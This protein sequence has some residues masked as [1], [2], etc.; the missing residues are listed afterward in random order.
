[1]ALTSALTSRYWQMVMLK[2]SGTHQTKPIDAAK[3]WITAHWQASPELVGSSDRTL[4]TDLWHLWKSH[5]DQ[6]PMAL[7]CLRCWVSHQIAA[8]C[9]QI[10]EQFGTSYGF[11]ASDLWPLVLDDDG[12]EI[13]AYQPLSMR[14]LERYD[15]TQAAL[16]TWANRMTKGHSEI[17]RF[18]LERGLYRI[19]DWALLND[20][21]LQGL[22]NA[23][24]HLSAAEIEAKSTLLAAYH[25]VY[26][27]DRIAQRQTKGRASRCQEPTP[28]Q[29][30]EISPKQPPAQVLRSLCEL[31][32]QMRAHRVSVRRGMPLTRPFDAAAENQSISRQCNLEREEDS[33]AQ[34][35]F[36]AR[37]RSHFLASLDGAISTVAEGF[38]ANY[39]KK[40][41]AKG[42]LFLSALTLFHCEGLSMGAI[43]Q[44]IGLSSQVQVTR[45][46]KLKRFRTEVCAYWFNQL[47]EQVESDV[48]RLMSPERLSAIAQQLDTVLSEETDAV[49]TEAAAEAQISKNRGVNST[50]AKRLCAQLSPEESDIKK[51]L[52]ENFTAEK[53]E[54][55]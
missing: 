20:V 15:P 46:L 10:A 54:N 5:S 26:R 12:Q 43:A 51:T 3:A 50:F 49:M 25:R 8:A 36:V 22:Q 29:L 19:S 45:L 48:L 24:T 39:R 37:Y 28:E 7:L 23:L 6:S 32:T 16:S 17:N 18:C 47:K 41:P 21:S 35:A 14:I 40:K 53:K 11:A 44:Q 1:M 4:Q 30:Q 33:G 52:E 42:K 55:E 34:E 13:R 2:G 38:A 9:Y 27:R 31:A